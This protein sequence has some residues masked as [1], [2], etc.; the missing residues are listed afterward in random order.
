MAPDRRLL[1]AN[2]VY[3]LTNDAAVTVMAGQITILRTDLQFGYVDVGLLTGAALLVTIVAQIVFGR[4][5][6]RRDP[7]RFLPI[8]IAFLGIASIAITTARSFLPFLAL[9]AVSRIGAGFY[10]PVGI[11][12]V[13]RAY[14]GADLDRAM[15]F[16]SSFG[17]LG[18]ILGMGSGALLGSAY[19][20]EAPF[21]LWGALNL[22]AVLL[23]LILVRGRRSPPVAPS[24]RVDYRAVIRDVRFWILPIA[25]G[26]AAFNIISN[27]GPILMHDGYGLPDALSGVFI[28]L[29]ILVGSVAAF[30]FGRLSALFGRYRSLLAAYLSLAITGFVAALLGLPAT[31]AVLWTLGSALFITYPA[32]FSFIS[33]AARTRG[34]GAAFGMI[35]AFQLLGGTLGVL[36]AGALAQAF[37]SPAVPFLLVGGLCGGGFVYLLAVRSRADSGLP[38]DAA[39]KGSWP[40]KR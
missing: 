11:G 1:L 18:V 9:V 27:F 34:Q 28:A 4:M 21:Y 29:W 6:D 17:D 30:F 19:G 26:G 23:G 37:N 5:A 32:T 36:A 39:T 16:Q 8:G 12:W 3:H 40:A 15:G 24:A 2:S 35:F 7:S 33:D 14:A 13:G 22:A 38:G 31:L 20:W 10:H 25:I